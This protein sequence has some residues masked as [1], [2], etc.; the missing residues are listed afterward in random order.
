MAGMTAA[1]ASA[2]TGDK[3]VGHRC[4]LYPAATTIEDTV[5][6]VKDVSQYA[7]VWCEIDARRLADG[8]M[9]SFH[10]PTWKR[11]ADP[12]S[13]L[14]AGVTADSPVAAATWAQVSKIRTKGGAPIA[15]IED[16]IAAGAQYDVGLIAELKGARASAATAKR[17]VDLASSQGADIWWYQNPEKT[18][19][20]G[21]TLLKNEPF[22]A[23]GGKI[24]VKMTLTC[25]FTPAELQARGATFI[26]ERP[27]LL[28]KE[29]V[30]AFTA[31]GV[32]S[33][34]RN[35]TATNIKGL[36][37]NGVW[38]V[39]TNYPKDAVNW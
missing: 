5:A 19:E 39:M 9:I 31:K 37:A 7:G 12:A 17:L 20:T 26:S 38:R 24:G 23:A 29:S 27:S 11:V 13:L 32:T 6:A 14:D 4:S 35:G 21:C 1:P 8:S 2:V 22:K 16:M 34:A 15:R 18:P 10:D 33:I 28:T 30:A 36:L 3:L 25:P